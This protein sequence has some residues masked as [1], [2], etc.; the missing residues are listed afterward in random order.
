M[1]IYTKTGDK[2]TTSLFTDQVVPKD[3]IRVEAYGTIDELGSFIGFAKV[4]VNDEMRAWLEDIQ[5]QL[6]V[7]G[8]ILASEGEEY[9]YKVVEQDVRKLERI[10]DD[11]KTRDTF[12]SLEHFI[13][14]GSS[15]ESARLHLART[16]CRRAERLMV[17]LDREIGTDPMAIKYVNRLSDVLYTMARFYEAEETYVE[18]K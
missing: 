5:Q 1:D 10:I 18:W 3:N 7:V 14:P 12:P 9:P 2:G 6:F 13:I 16:V 17:T 8:G 11:L 15:E 4:K